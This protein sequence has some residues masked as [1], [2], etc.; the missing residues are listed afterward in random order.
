[1]TKIIVKFWEVADTVSSKVTAKILAF[2]FED[3][4]GVMRR[5]EDD[6]SMAVPYAFDVVV[7]DVI[8]PVAVVCHIFNVD[9]AEEIRG[10]LNNIDSPAD[11][12]LTT[13]TDE[14]AKQI[15][16]K[17]ADWQR[18]L[19][20]VRVLPNRGRDI[21][22][23]YVGCRDV[24]DRYEFVLFLHSK[25]SRGNAWATEWR[26]DLF[27]SLLGSPLIV[28][29]ILY[30]MQTRSDIGIVL[31]QNFGPVREYV[32]WH[33]HFHFAKKIASRMNITLRPDRMIDF[34][35]GSM[36]WARSKALKP[37]LDLHL[38]VEDFPPERAQRDYTLAH[39][40]ER[41]LL[42]V[43][44]S[45]GFIWVKVSVS[46]KRTAPQ[47]AVNIAAPSE[48]STFIGKYGVSLHNGSEL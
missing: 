22:P 19:V 11:L 27:D 26:R 43:C 32:N 23:K 35:A 7:P 38:K 12:Y 36:F 14:K 9:L 8:T 10:Y 31:P 21:A 24:Y 33:G 29:S 18:G 41:L 3:I 20:D 40:L 17:F 48:I 15:R 46:S 39:V 5:A 37:I 45:A 30:L 25:S 4:I 47:T 42:Y 2:F 6:F 34:A 44:E 13:D 1:M 28:K 16:A